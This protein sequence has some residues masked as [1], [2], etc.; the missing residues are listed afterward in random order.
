MGFDAK[1]VLEGYG[2]PNAVDAMTRWANLTR[3]DAEKAVLAAG[4]SPEYKAPPR[5]ARFMTDRELSEAVDAALAGGAPP[6]EGDESARIKGAARDLKER[7][8]RLREVLSDVHHRISD[9]ER[10]HGMEPSLSRALTGADTEQSALEEAWDEACRKPE[11]R[12]ID[13]ELRR[14]SDK[15]TAK[16]M[17]DYLGAP[18]FCCCATVAELTDIVEKKNSVP[19]SVNYRFASLTADRGVAA[20]FA[21]ALD[22][23]VLEYDGDSIRDAGKSAPVKYS[24]RCSARGKSVGRGMPLAFCLEAE[25]R[26]LR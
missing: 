10:R 15:A 3:E 4:S 23:A 6:D 21:G 12:E 8:G 1:P 11:F 2:G 7:E 24:H 17:R 14:L 26:I 13:G 16:N 5:P 18:L 22:G 19:K 20:R 25:T 9:L